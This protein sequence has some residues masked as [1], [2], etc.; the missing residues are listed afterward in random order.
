MNKTE[1]RISVADG[2]FSAYLVLS[3][4]QPVA[5][6]IV[7]Q[8]ILGVNATIRRVADRYAEAG[9]LAIAPDLFW[10]LEPNVQLSDRK[11]E[12]KEKSFDLFGKFDVDL[13]IEDLKATLA[14]LRAHPHSNGKVGTVGFCL[15]GKLAY[16][17]ATRSDADCNVS[18]YG[19]EIENL[20]TESAQIQKPLLMHIAE[21]DEYVPPEA[22]ASIHADLNGNDRV[23]LYSYPNVSHAFARL[24]GVPYVKAAAELANERTMSFLRQNLA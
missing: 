20:L 12:D 7:I 17:M 15:G 13:G 22:Q 24:D 23:I 5:G 3:A 2:S 16:L 1:V 9:Y 6:V 10:R 19:V 14:Y 11:P 4:A 8:E 21:K 18:Y